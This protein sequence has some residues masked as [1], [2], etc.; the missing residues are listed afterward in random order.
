MIRIARIDNVSAMAFRLVAPAFPVSFL[1]ASPTGVFDALKHGACDVALLPVA[2]L[3]PLAHLVEPLGAYG[4]A[5]EGAVHSV[6]LDARYPLH[7]IVGQQRPVY[8]SDKSQTS[9]RLLDTLCRR[10]YGRSPRLVDAPHRADACLWI[11]EDALNGSRDSAC[12]PLHCDMGQ[13]WYE[14]T[15][16]P[17]VFARW[18]VRRNLPEAE[19]AAVADWLNISAT[20]ASTPEGREQL[21][22]MAA[23]WM[24]TRE[25]GLMYYGRIRP[26]LTLRDLQGQT[27]FLGQESEERWNIIA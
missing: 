1:G 15:S 5:C 18:V 25:F 4:I 21:A 2:C 17:F 6:M 12:W 19:K 27:T 9:R 7:V 11:G 24:P 23:R 14:R 8:V 13:W 10:D 3:R 26:R 16:L 22:R 20:A